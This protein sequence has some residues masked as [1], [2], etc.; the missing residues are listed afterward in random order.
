VG[1]EID[2]V[3]RGFGLGQASLFSLSMFSFVR[4]VT[5]LP[6]MN[7]IGTRNWQPDLWQS[8]TKKKAILRRKF[9]G[10]CTPF[11]YHE[12]EKLKLDR[13]IRSP[14][15]C[16]T[17][18]QRRLHASFLN[19]SQSFPSSCFGCFRNNTSKSRH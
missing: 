4:F 9:V 3:L 12:L 13:V 1:F 15:V 11:R 2:E 16:Y 19:V 5:V 14:I 18:A 10:Q 17:I 7:C 8:L 6:T